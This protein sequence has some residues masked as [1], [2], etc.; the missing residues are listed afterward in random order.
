MAQDFLTTSLLTDAVQ[1]LKSY[2]FLILILV[3]IARGF[4]KRYL[5]PLRAYP[6]PFLASCSRIWRLWVTYNGHS[7]HD[8][9]DVHRKYG[10][11]GHSWPWENKGLTTEKRPYRPHRPK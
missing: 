2:F 8:H 11:R 6:G 4:L 3:P 9:I 10:R 5:S 7:E 1:F